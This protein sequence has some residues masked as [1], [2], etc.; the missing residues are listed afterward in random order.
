LDRQRRGTIFRRHPWE[1]YPRFLISHKLLIDETYAA[2]LRDW[3][4]NLRQRSLLILDEAHH[5]APSS[6]SRYAI[7]SRFTRAVRDLA[8]RFEHRLFL[9]ATPHN[10]HSNSFSALLDLLDPQRFTRGVKVVKRNLEDV[11]VRRL[12]EDIRQLAGGL[13]E[14]KVCQID[15]GADVVPQ[16]APELVLS[17]LLEGYRKVR[18]TRMAGATKRKQAEAGLLVIHLQQRLL[19][20]VE[21]FARTLAVHRRTMERLWAREQESRSDFVR[22]ERQDLDL[23][24]DAVDRDDDRSQ[25]PEEELQALEDLQVET[26][27]EL[28]FGDQTQADR[29]REQTLLDEMHDIAEAGR[30]VPDARLRCLI[31]WIRKN[32]CEGARVPGDARPVEN[33]KWNDLRILIFTEYDDTKRYLVN[34]LQNAIEGTELAEHRILVFHGP[35]PP[36][37]REAIKRAF[38][39]PPNEHPV[40][41]L[42][43]TDAAREGLNLQ[44]H[45]HH[46]FHIDV[47]WNPSRLEQRN[48]RIDRKMQPAPKV[49]CHY[50]VYIDRPEDRV[51][52]ALVRKTDTIRRELGS[53][54]DVLEARLAATLRHGIHHN[55]IEKLEQEITNEGIDENKRSVTDEELEATR[56]RRDELE[57]QI[58]ALRAR[59]NDAKKWIGLETNELRDA[60]S[61]SLEILGSEPLKPAA[62]NNGGPPRY[63]FPNLAAR[64]GADPTWAATLETLRVPPENGKR[65]FKR[66]KESPTRPVVFS[67]PNEIDDDVV[68]LHLSHRV[69]Q[70]L[71]GWFLAQGFVHHDLSRACL[72]DAIITHNYVLILVL[73][74]IGGLIIGG[75]IHGWKL[76]I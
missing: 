1:T 74:G 16:D 37:K 68:Q 46:V 59:I 64:R 61:C 11:M 17:R 10:G 66:R 31:D 27:T 70:R 67:A 23:L 13:P 35:T 45:C 47:P 73:G 53:L 9:S 55:E 18:A 34:M 48:G 33:A 60:L 21:A 8:S 25:L 2:P 50:F 22:K 28:G 65:D 40:R 24:S 49:F 62:G 26:A 15:L 54:A 44:A 63:V 12:K 20:S 39:L 14:R 43:A 5:A 36:D 41:I 52:R 19:S 29:E 57:K 75:L 58:D 7:D 4:D 56:A 6:G 38:N 72:P 76:H 71:L 3:L 51:L 42:V 69:A 30:G 32:M